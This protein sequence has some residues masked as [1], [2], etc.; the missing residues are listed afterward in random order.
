MTPC[1][2]L[3]VTVPSLLGLPVMFTLC[4]SAGVVVECTPS[5]LT[6]VAVGVPGQCLKTSFCIYPLAHTLLL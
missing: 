6:Q 2:S 5:P 3:L 1:I 4:L